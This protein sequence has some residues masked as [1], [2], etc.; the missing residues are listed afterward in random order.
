VGSQDGLNNFNGYDFN[1]FKNNPFDSTTLTHNW[2]WAIAEDRRGDLWV[3]TFQGLCKYVRSEDRFIQ[4]Y[5]DPKNPASIS[6]NRPNA[7]IKDKKGRIWISVWGSGLNLYDE[8]TNSFIRFKYNESDVN[9]ISSNSV[10]SLFCDAA[11]TVWV[12]TWNNGL[13]RVIED[14]HGFRFHRYGVE[15]C[16][17]ITTL[18]EDTDKNLWIGSYESGVCL[19]ND[20]RDRFSKLPDFSQND[21]NK[22]IFDSKGNGW[23]GTNS[24]LYFYD[25]ATSKFINFKNEPGNSFSISSNT[26][27]AL[28]ED[29]KGIIWF[30]GVGLDKFD[31]KKNIFKS[32][33]RDRFVWTFCE[34][35]EH[36][37]WIGSENNAIDIFDPATETFQQLVV[38]DTHGVPVTNIHR[39]VFSKGVFWIASFKHGLTRYEK[40]SGKT[41]SFLSNHPSILGKIS[42]IEDVLIDND[43]SIWVATN[44]NGLIHYF[45]DTQKT[46]Q[47]TVNPKDIDHT[48]GS[49]FINSLSKDTNGN[50]WIG[51][52]GGGMSM[53]DR[54]TMKFVNYQYDRKNNNGLSDQIVTG[55]NQDDSVFWIC[56]HSGLN[57]LNVNT[58]TFTHFFEKD[59][60]PNN[61]TYETLKDSNGNL[62]ISTNGGIS[63]FTIN[64]GKFKNYTSEDGL[65]NNEFNSNAALKSK[66]GDFYFGG[67]NGFTVFKPDKL[68]DDNVPPTVIISSFHVFDKHIPIP[69]TP[70]NLPYDQNYISFQFTA[71]EYSSPEKIKFECRL[72]GFDTDWEKIGNRRFA[73]YTNLDPGTYTFSVRATNAD[74]YRS[75][76]ETNLR[77][78]IAPPFWKTWW[79]VCL[80]VLLSLSIIYFIHNYRLNQSLKFERLRNKIASDLHD[81][82]GSSLT[83]I[84]IYSDLIQN[85]S[86]ITEQKNYLQQISEMSREV[87]STMSDIVWSIDNRNDSMGAL[88]IRMKDFAAELLHSKNI[89]LKFVVQGVDET[90]TL[91]PAL[92][93]NIYL[94]F[95]ESIHNI[96][97]HAKATAVEVSL[98]NEDNFFQMTIRDDGKGFVQNGTSKGNGLRNMQRRS[99]DIDA[100]FKIHQ[101]NGTTILIKRSM[102]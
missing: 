64:T 102:I 6:G 15:S 29:K 89:E 48:I 1:V 7:L 58:N 77:F 73:T 44:E 9:S 13:N 12:G 17:Q 59:G 82:V 51:F 81:E 100:E 69:Q 88:V 46:E 67:I 45:P 74:G 39:I 78:T 14:E 10:R 2:V 41:Y 18:A 68:K 75:E 31:P 32:F 72:D 56:T 36:K 95:K 86:E 85:G 101:H 25:W 99:R 52:W 42:L 93:Q 62:W 19:L 49:N 23:I 91:D 54:Q 94:I 97:K 83:R 3:G 30:S 55:I 76:S 43:N 57:K 16:N 26:I 28:F 65:Q 98:L 96:L 5:N 27:Y 38:N 63:R 66:S 70:L 24:G 33:L 79:F 87:V 37:I 11:G 92:K 34:D 71:F 21:V 61:V 20:K 50:I 35:D 4:F 53:L 60:L 22:I 40:T 84:S 47:Y 90:K 8:K 80:I